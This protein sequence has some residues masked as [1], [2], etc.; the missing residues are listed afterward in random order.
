MRALPLTLRKEKC[1]G[2]TEREGPVSSAKEGC[3]D[4]KGELHHDF[5]RVRGKRGGKKVTS[6]SERKKSLP[7]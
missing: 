1:N 4:N 7:N 2:F 3:K 5:L 6:S